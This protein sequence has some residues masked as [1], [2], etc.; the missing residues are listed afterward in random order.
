RP[1]TGPRSGPTCSKSWNCWDL[2]APGPF[3][4]AASGSR[5]G[6]PSGPRQPSR[7]KKIVA[8][9]A[10]GRNR[11]AEIAE[12]SLESRAIEAPNKPP[13]D[14]ALDLESSAGFFSGPSAGRKR[15]G[16]S[17]GGPE[18]KGRGRINCGERHGSAVSR[19]N[20]VR[21]PAEGPRSTSPGTA[22]R[23]PSPHRR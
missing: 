1:K 18:L 8:T 3:E 7:T 10:E 9:G 17:T 21:F 16:R 14:P 20:P 2:S 11:L 12:T 6:P 4:A 13:R 15:R 5:R 19:R 23:R 22:G